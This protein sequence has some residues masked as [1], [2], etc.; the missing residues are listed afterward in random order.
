MQ[1]P[2]AARVRWPPV[3]RPPWARILASASLLIAVTAVGAAVTTDLQAHARN[4]HVHDEVAAARRTLATSRSELAAGL[5]EKALVTDHRDAVQAAEAT[6]L[7]QVANT[8]RNLSS[9]GANATAQ[10]VDIGTLQTCL[11]GVQSSFQQISHRNNNQAAQDISSVSTACLALAGDDSAGLV[12][13]F[14]F[15]DPDVLLVGTTYFGYATNSV[16]GNIQIIESTDL[17]HW[18]AV[19]NALPTLPT[20]AAP[21]ATWA[22]AVAQIGTS[23]ILYYAAVVA[24][25]G[26]GEEC[27]SAATASQPQ[28]PF[29]DP[30]TSPLECQ[31]ALD[32]S[33]DPSP[34]IDTDGT[35]YLVWKSNGGSGPATIWSEQL[36]P[37]GTGFAPGAAPSQ[38]LVP[39]QSWEAGIVEA[40]D[41]VTSGGRYFLFYSG[42]SW[43]SA[44]YAVGVATCRGPL[45]PCTKP[46]TNPILA[47][48]PGADGPGGESVFADT[49]GSYWVAYHAWIPGA[50]GYP[51]NR[52]LYLRRLDLSGAIPVL[53]P[54]H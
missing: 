50:V 30:S 27:V 14:D 20:W 1:S 15:P 35:P 16:A 32:G 22:P 41:L 48:G 8:Q 31:T 40:P 29:I 36:D 47:S 53:G 52:D 5:W 33:L 9:T 10:Q 21:D 51:N 4:R 18:N 44:N 46:L 23:F 28:G 45:G 2:P 11:G 26:G 19:G 34:F 6:T 17:T 7:A 39:T 24:G 42:N 25:P 3:A 43:N 37:V 49:S 38:L 54:A 13:P 12:Y